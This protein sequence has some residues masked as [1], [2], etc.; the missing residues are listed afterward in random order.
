MVST[1]WARDRSSN[2]LT[3]GSLQPLIGRDLAPSVP[4]HRPRAAE[5][6][7]DTC[8]ALRP[9]RAP[10]SG[11]HP[12]SAASPGALSSPARPHRSQSALAPVSEMDRSSA[13]R[14]LLT[15]AL[16]SGVAMEIPPPTIRAEFGHKAT[17]PC[18]L[19]SNENIIWEKRAYN[20]SVWKFIPSEG[21]QLTLE[22]VDSSDL[23]IYRCRNL[24][25]D[26]SCEIGLRVYRV[27]YLRLFNLKESEKNVILM[28]EG[29]LLLACV[30]IPGTILLREKSQRSLRERI[31]RYKEENENLYQGLNQEEQGTYED[32]TRGQQSMYQDVAN[33]RRSGIELEK[34]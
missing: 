18:H 15:A 5:A 21:R 26:T 13:L 25:N 17:L 20:S 16:L 10:R 14:L 28:V 19:E 27:P 33:Y 23:G 4:L 7:R 1:C 30:V 29:I 3:P 22:N 8:S 31:Q 2:V 32:I 34:P 9:L 12:A 24:S 11:K 6:V